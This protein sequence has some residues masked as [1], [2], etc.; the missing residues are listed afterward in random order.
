MRKN[1]LITGAGRGIGLGIARLFAKKKHN[2][3]LTVRKRSQIGNL[4]KLKNE[5]I[6]I[7]IIIGDFKDESILKKLKKI[8]KI[9]N[10]ICNASG[11]NTKF[12]TKVSKKELDEMIKTNL[13]TTFRIKQI[14]AQQMIKNK[15][16]GSIINISSQLG[17]TGAFNRSLYCMSKF[18]IEGLTKAMALDLGKYGIRVN[19]VSPTKTIVKQNEINKQTKRLKL[20]KSKIPLNK[21]STVE[22]IAGIVF[23][24]TTKDASS[25]TGTSLISDGGWTAGK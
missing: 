7:K 12:F 3:V 25:I 13:S 16:K 22:E 20:I 24:L 5:N 2:L 19:T 4:I 21:F 1:T 6:N 14:F 11:E 18:A 10:L 23:F 15:T 8:K 9:D 17:H